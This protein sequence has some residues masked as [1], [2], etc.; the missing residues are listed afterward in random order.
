MTLFSVIFIVYSAFAG[1][2]IWF[3]GFD[4]LLNTSG[5]SGFIIF[6][7]Y[8]DHASIS[9]FLL[10]VM[11]LI[12]S[13][14]ITYS[15]KHKKI[16]LMEICLLISLIFLIL[17]PWIVDGISDLVDTITMSSMKIQKNTFTP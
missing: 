11:L 14:F 2:G 16:F 7:P 13:L 4:I 1:V 9:I 15:V 5:R 8:F 10:L 17:A 12:Y 6:K 3:L